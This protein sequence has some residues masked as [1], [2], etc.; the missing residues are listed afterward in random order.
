MGFG[1]GRANRPN[2]LKRRDHPDDRQMWTIGSDRTGPPTPSHRLPL[3]GWPD[4]GV[5]VDIAYRGAGN[6]VSEVA[7]TG[8]ALLADLQEVPR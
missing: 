1:T 4:S 8:L 6:C 7:E 5:A 3:L 2:R